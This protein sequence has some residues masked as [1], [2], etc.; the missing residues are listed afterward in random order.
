M[1]FS[2]HPATIAD[3]DAMASCEMEA[4][5]TDRLNRSISGKATTADRH[6]LSVKYYEKEFKNAHLNGGRFYK[7]I[8]DENG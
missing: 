5:S 6:P 1:P 8:D 2:I 7:A 3:A 4:F